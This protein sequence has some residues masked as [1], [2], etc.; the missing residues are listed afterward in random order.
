[1]AYIGLKTCMQGFVRVNIYPWR[2]LCQGLGLLWT[3]FSAGIFI[4]PWGK[5]GEE[6]IENPDLPVVFSRL[7]CRH[8]PRHDIRFIVFFTCI[9]CAGPHSPVI[10][11]TSSMLCILSICWS[12][13]ICRCRH[14]CYCNK[15]FNSYQT[16]LCQH[17]RSV[18]TWSFVAWGDWESWQ[19]QGGEYGTA[20]RLLRRSYK[21]RSSQWT[22]VTRGTGGVWNSPALMSRVENSLA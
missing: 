17:Q 11:R 6:K 2:I 8:L 14:C 12:L 13:H 19:G 3:L 5:R 18:S 15:C 7:R 22:Q 20:P 4:H 1:M 21:P 16:S 9:L 10:I